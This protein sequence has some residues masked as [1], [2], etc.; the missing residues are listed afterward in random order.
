VK[1]S[2]IAGDVSGAL[3]GGNSPM[4][5]RN[6]VAPTMQPTTT[7]V[8]LTIYMGIHGTIMNGVPTVSRL[9]HFY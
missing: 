1:D 6:R 5:N 8:G 9:T 3:T 7:D 4:I 2:V